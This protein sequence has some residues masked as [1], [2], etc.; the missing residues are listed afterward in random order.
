MIQAAKQR[1]TSL[2]AAMDLIPGSLLTDTFREYAHAPQWCSPNGYAV[3]DA[4]QQS[5]VGTLRRIM[6]VEKFLTDV[7]AYRDRRYPKEAA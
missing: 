2:R 4:K 1:N 5:G 3:G 7:A 6:D